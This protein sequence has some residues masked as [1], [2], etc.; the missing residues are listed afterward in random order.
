MTKQNTIFD[1]ADKMLEDENLKKDDEL[2]VT[3]VKIIICFN[4]I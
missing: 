2:A 1:Y 4:S 3:I